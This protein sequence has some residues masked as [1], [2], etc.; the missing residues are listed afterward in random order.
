MT[1]TFEC[2]STDAVLSADEP[3]KC[4][5]ASRFATPAACEPKH[6]EALR[7]E[8][9]GGDEEDGHDEL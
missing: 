3:E 2:G 1:V 6:A 9:E 8:L 5:Y 7:L 4:A